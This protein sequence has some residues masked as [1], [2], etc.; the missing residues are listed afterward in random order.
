MPRLFTAL[1]IPTSVATQL[2]MLQSGLPGARW[3]ER[4]DLHITLR[5]IGDVE[6]PVARELAQALEAVK[7]KPFSLK[8][9]RLDVFGN[10]KPHSL[11]AGVERCDALADLRTEQDRICQRLGLEADSRKFTPH[12]TIARIRGSKTP[13]LAKYLSGAGGFQSQGFQVNRFVLMSSRDSFGGG[14][15]VRE[16]TYELVEQSSVV[17]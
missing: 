13:D 11:F 1:E 17:A 3:I 15:Y 5:F 4:E 14:P 2:S 8:L 12:V 9:D 7:T 16:E 6:L 10:A